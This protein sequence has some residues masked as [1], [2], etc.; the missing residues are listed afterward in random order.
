MNGQ[1]PAGLQEIS[2]LRGM[3]YECMNC[4]NELYVNAISGMCCHWWGKKL[5]WR[6][7]HDRE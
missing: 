6:E 1:E 7:R 3:G 4:G 2:A 5:K